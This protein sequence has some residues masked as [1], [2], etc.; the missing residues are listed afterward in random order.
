M[1]VAAFPTPKYDV[2]LV[3][4][5]GH[6]DYIKNMVSGASQ[7]EAAIVVVSADPAELDAALSE[8]GQT[9]EHLLLAYT[10]GIKQLVVAVN[11]MDLVG[12][13]EAAFAAASEKIQAALKK[14]GYPPKTVPIV[15]VSG[16][17][18]DNLTKPAPAKVSFFIPCH[19]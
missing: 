7:S 5:P 4:T 18:G 8:Y 2:T 17:H 11:K 14:V 1:K 16:F 19:P 15:P 13:E 6:E 10:V 9:R 12:Y 3:D